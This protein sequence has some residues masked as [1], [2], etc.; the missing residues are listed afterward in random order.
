MLRLLI[1]YRIT[2]LKPVAAID[3]QMTSEVG[4]DKLI[5]YC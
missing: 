5:L 3:S 2:A 4:V 1:A